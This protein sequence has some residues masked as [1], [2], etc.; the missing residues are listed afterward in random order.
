MTSSSND[1]E[2]LTALRKANAMLAASNMNWQ[3]FISGIKTVTPR[4]A[5]KPQGRGMEDE[6]LSAMRKARRDPYGSSHQHHFAD[7]KIPGMLQ[8]LLRDAKGGFHDF[9]ESVNE[10][11]HEHG[12]LTERQ[13]EAIVNAYERAK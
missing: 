11:W 8:S 1:G 3:E 10:Y 4:P 7:P 6:N 9:V 2:A 5:P 13:Y 12:Y